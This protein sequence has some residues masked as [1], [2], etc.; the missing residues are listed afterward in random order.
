MRQNYWEKRNVPKCVRNASKLRQ[1]CAEHLWGRTPFGRYRKNAKGKNFWK[2]CR[3][4]KCS[5]KIFQK[6]SQKIED[7]I[8]LDFKVFL[9]IF[10][11]FAEECFLLRSFRKFS[12]SGFVPL[13]RFQSMSNGSQ[14]HGVE[15]HQFRGQK[16]N[17]KAKIARTAPKNFLNNS[18]ALPN[19]TRVWGKSHQ[20][21]H[22]K[23][24]RNLCRKSSLGYLCCPWS[25]QTLAA[26]SSRNGRC[27]VL[28]IFET[29]T[30]PPDP[31]SAKTPS[32]K[33]KFQKPRKPD[34][35]PK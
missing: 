6:I 24:R 30:G 12:P 14:A 19:K 28:D 20:K 23:V 11:I 34:Y 22:P 29:P 16:K 18:R 26:A 3:R 32:N 10:E 9:D 21:V 5:Q 15:A 1:K 2:L 4:R 25:I 8:L 7:I 31:R 13:S 35:P 17:P 33:K 27:Y